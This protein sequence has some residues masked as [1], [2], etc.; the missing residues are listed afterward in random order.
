MGLSGRYIS[1]K[2]AIDRVYQDAGLEVN[3]TEAIEWVGDV[4]DL[5]GAPMLY[6]TV[7]TNGL[8]DEDGITNDPLIITAY[9]AE[10]P[11]DVH[12]II[13]CLNYETKATMYEVTDNFYKSYGSEVMPNL[14]PENSYITNNAYIFTG[15]E[16]GSLELAYSA[17]K[18]D[19][20]GFPMI[21]DD[22][23]VVRAIT[24][25]ITERLDY[26][27]WR[28]G[29]ITSQIY[30]QSKRD[31]YFDM[32]AATTRVDIPSIDKME[33]WKRMVINLNPRLKLHSTGFRLPAKSANAPTT[34]AGLNP[35]ISRETSA[36]LVNKTGEFTYDMAANTWLDKIYI[37]PTIGTPS[38]KIGTSYDGSEICD[39]TAIGTFLQITA[40]LRFAYA[41]TI[42]FN[43]TGGNATLRLDY[44]PNLL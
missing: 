12:K 10:L 8:E 2:R 40:E 29:R 5:I 20:D 43:I 14:I 19:S 34:G 6:K 17:Y 21:P 42:Y 28:I 4:L 41:G 22:T 3:N 18:L 36:E 33:S 9:R 30:E 44:I 11:L 25:Y 37:E 23:K 26:R 32:G 7:I 38:I 24:S 35:S 31:R 1:C 15:Y 13:G 39:T 16:T 27:S